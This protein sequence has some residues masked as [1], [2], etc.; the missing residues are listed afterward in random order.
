[1][2]DPAA[3]RRNISH[4]FAVANDPLIQ[5]LIENPLYPFSKEDSYQ[6]SE[7]TYR[8]IQKYP[9]SR[10]FLLGKTEIVEA[11]IQKMAAAIDENE[12]NQLIKLAESTQKNIG[13][14]KYQALVHLCYTSEHIDLHDLPSILHAAN[15]IGGRAENSFAH[16]FKLLQENSWEKISP[17]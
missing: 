8:F 5:Y 13:V 9:L 11:N 1:M 3:L 4:K 7:T 17:Q 14:E 10:L 16:F 6:L 2:Q 15:K 12:H